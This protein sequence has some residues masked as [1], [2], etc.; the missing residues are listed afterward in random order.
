[1]SAE[2]SEHTLRTQKSEDYFCVVVEP[3]IVDAIKTSRVSAPRPGISAI[4][5]KTLGA[6]QYF[7]FDKKVFG[8]ADNIKGNR[9]Q[10][11]RSAEFT[12]VVGSMAT[13][14]RGTVAEGEDVD[15]NP[16]ILDEASNLQNTMLTLAEMDEKG[17]LK[18]PKAG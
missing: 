17:I 15:L 13:N 5:V 3:P 18:T 12:H 16:A 9:L 11:S 1:M 14:I 2:A 7:V 8:W 4:L 6:E 10:K